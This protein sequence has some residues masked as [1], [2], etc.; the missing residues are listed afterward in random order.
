MAE[1]EARM[2]KPHHLERE[3]CLYVRQSS[4]RQVVKN[5]ESGR[6]QYG[7]DKRAVALGWPSDR[8]RVIDEDQGKSGAYS[9]NRSGF[10]D[11]LA[12]VAAGEVGIVLG[13]EVSRLA[14]DNADWHQLL[15][16]AGTT[17][18]LILD[19][20]GVY[21]PNDVN[22]RLLLGIRCR[23][24]HLIP[25]VVQLLMSGSDRNP[26]PARSLFRDCPT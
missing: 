14:R 3:A 8:I 13:L 1:A 17:D 19:E 5:T 9:G 7:L 10:R 18:T 15:K 21:D 2:I 20:T 6:R 12:R 11:L 22:H 23:I 16:I 25:Y 24:R 4:L 26:L